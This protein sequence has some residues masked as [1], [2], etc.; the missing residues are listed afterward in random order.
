MNV[1]AIFT[2]ITDPA[3]FVHTST[4]RTAWFREMLANQIAN[5]QQAIVCIAARNPQSPVL[6]IK[7]ARINHCGEALRA[8][9][10]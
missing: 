1:S 7:Q 9:Q 8:L 3:G 6:A 10:A 5:D 2:E 4:V